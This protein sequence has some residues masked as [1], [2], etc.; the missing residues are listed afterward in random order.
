MREQ[1]LVT[2]RSLHARPAALLADLAA[3]FDCSIKLEA[4]GRSANAKSVLSLMALDLEIGD[5]VLVQ[6]DG[7]DDETAAR[8]VAAMLGVAEERDD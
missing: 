1:T 6:A 8:A 4:G 7:D 5:K 3:G 2:R